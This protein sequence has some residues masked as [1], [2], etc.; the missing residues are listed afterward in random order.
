MPFNDYE[1]LLQKL[2][3]L[4][5]QINCIKTGD[6][7]HKHSNVLHQDNSGT[8]SDV[9]DAPD[10]A[11]QIGNPITNTLKY[12]TLLSGR[13]KIT[14]IGSVNFEEGTP[15]ADYNLLILNMQDDLTHDLAYANMRFES[16]KTN[17]KYPFRYGE[18]T[19]KEFSFTHIAEFD[20]VAGD[21]IGLAISDGGL[22]GRIGDN[23]FIVDKMPDF[24]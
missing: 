4:E 16:Y 19:E 17:M 2:T 22:S 21:W 14:F 12:Q 1:T 3:H 15:A 10:E 18:R 5:S 8:S 9:S 20:V 13:Y 6:C 7:C 11:F 24:I 23:T